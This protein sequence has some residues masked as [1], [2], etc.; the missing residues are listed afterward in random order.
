MTAHKYPV[1]TISREYCAGGTS[2]ARGISE[3]LG[4][5]FYHHDFVKETAANSGYSEADIQREGEDLSHAAKLMDGILNSAV[6]YSSSHD[7]IFQAQKETILRLAEED[8]II[9]GRCSN[10]ILKEAGIPCFNIFL[11][12]DMEH[13]MKRAIEL[14]QNPESSDLKK[15]VQKRDNLRETYYKTYTGHVLGDYHN[16]DISLDTGVLG[17]DTCIEILADLI[18]HFQE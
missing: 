15:Y 11:H 16:Y 4:I 14:G 12:A 3:K 1:I 10:I 7:G 5:P 18:G 17:Y 2:I 6:S 13:R 8:C 9:I